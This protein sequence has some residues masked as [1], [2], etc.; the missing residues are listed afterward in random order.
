[1]SNDGHLTRSATS[2]HTVSP[3]ISNDSMLP[4]NTKKRKN[5]SES[6]NHFTIVDEIRKKVECNYCEKPIKYS[7]GT[8]VMRAHLTRCHDIDDYVSRICHVVWYVRSSGLRL[9]AVKSYIN[10][11][12]EYKVRMSSSSYLTSNIYMFEILGIGKSFVEMCNSEDV[13]LRSTAQAMKK[14][15]DKYW[16][17]YK[18]INMMLLIALVFDPRCKMKLTDWMMRRFYSEDD[19]DSLKTLLESCLKSLFEEYYFGVMPPQG[20]N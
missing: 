1:M 10:E 9:D 15:Y 2:E 8:S 7:N 6:W 12:L 3:T 17:N 20:Y 4:P 19:S 14:K 5:R 13:H 18:S 16:E 11:S